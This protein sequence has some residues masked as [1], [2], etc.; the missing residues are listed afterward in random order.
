MK[1]VFHNVCLTS[2]FFLTYFTVALSAAAQIVPDATLP[3]NSAVTT[4]GQVHA[5]N[6]GTT[7][8]VNLY[9]SFQDF[10]VP[11][12]NTAYF[13]NASQVQNILT[14]VTGSSASDI[15]GTLRANGNANLYLLNPNGITFGQNAKLEI[16]GSFTGSTASSF[17]FSDGSEFS[18]KNP[19]APPLLT[20]SITPGLQYGQ[21][22]SRSTLSNASSLI[23]REG[24]GITLQGGSISSTGVLTAP[25][26]TVQVLGSHVSLLNNAL[27]DVSGANG[28]GTVLIG[29]DYQ[30]KGTVPNAS[31]THVDRGVT[32][33]ADAL[34]NGNGGRIIIWADKLTEF[35]G[36][37]TAKGVN[38][39]NPS[40]KGDGGFVEISGKQNLIFDGR[41]D[42]RAANGK[43]GTLLLDPTNV[44][45]SNG[46][47]LGTTL[48]QASLETQLSS[49]NVTI[50]ATNEIVIG[51]LDGNT[52][53]SSLGSITFIADSDGDNIGSFSMSPFDLIRA[54]ERNVSISGASVTVGS[55]QTSSSIING[56]A[57][58]G[59]DISISSTVG[60]ITTGALIASSSTVNGN[61][62]NG[63]NITLSSFGNIS[64]NGFSAIDSSSSTSNGSAG[65]GGDIMLSSFTGNIFTQGLLNSYSQTISGGTTG[66]GG[67]ISLITNTGNISTDFIQAYSIAYSYTTGGNSGNGGTISLTTNTGNISTAKLI[68]WSRSDN[69]IAGNG[70]AISLRTNVGN[71]S[72]ND[73]RSMSQG[74]NASIGGT[75]TLATNIG[76][77]STGRF[78]SSGYGTGGNGG[79]ITLTAN[80]GNISTESLDASSY[81]IYSNAN[82]GGALSL[83]TNVGNIS[84]GDLYS[85]SYA[86]SAQGNPNA[87]DGGNISL[88]SDLGNIFINGNV[89]SF[90][91]SQDNATTRNGGIIS[92]SARQGDI[93][94][95]PNKSISS[96]SVA[97]LGIAGNAGN[98]FIEAKNSIANLSISTLSSSTG[99]GTVQITGTGDVSILNTNIITSNFLEIPDPLAPSAPVILPIPNK[100]GSSGAVSISGIGNLTFNN[101]SIQSDTKGSNPAGNVTI[102][103]QGSIFFDRSFVNSSTS[104]T[105]SAGNIS[106]MANRG[107]TITGANSGLFAQTKSS[108]NAGNINVTA[109]DLTLLG[110]ASIQT[111]TLSS[112]LAGNIEV[113]VANNFSLTG[114]GTGLFSDTAFGSSGNGGNIFVDPQLVT[115]QDGAKISVGSL[116]SGIGG[117]IFIF[118]DRLI[119][120]N[121][122]S[123][124]AE[125]ASSNGGN[126]TLNIPAYLL[127]RNG[128]QISTTAGTALAGGNGGNININAGFIIGVKG[129][130]SDIFANAF[131]GNGGNVNITTN[132]IYGLEFRPLLTSFSDITA[133]SQ[134]GLNG[135]VSITTPGLDPSRGLTNLPVNLADPSKQVSQSCAIGG[136]LANR[137]NRFTISGRGGL[138]KSPTDE[139]SSIHPLVELA[140]LVP[141][142]TNSISATEQKQEVTQQVPKRIVEAN[143][144]VRDSQGV[145]HLVA[146]SNPLSPAIPQLSCP[147]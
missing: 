130:N 115:L 64:T 109:N 61:A 96:F 65:N 60:N 76:D 91:F 98:I 83:T 19:Q 125:T 17:K 62:G 114:T 15:D 25:G 72:T 29:G 44:I 37:V 28:G 47:T 113:R 7:R 70:G 85:Y 128:S 57:G 116:G 4:N 89:F 39:T 87:G 147:Q 144:L 143:T 118:A 141:S 73:I 77:I 145:L 41:V 21:T 105:G 50:D 40:F 139:L 102:I 88:K 58:D 3:V 22:D 101:S 38:L 55:I 34:Q 104:S 131:K 132:G 138:P 67:A 27:I 94:A 54:S 24:Q 134:F 69:G 99:A 31:E 140:D 32:I 95:S 35:Y 103:S 92:L 100:L 79:T 108:G 63:G 10:S 112:G 6:G 127:L 123:I 18:A 78:E 97:Q 119:L 82:N 46:S 137:D 90:S 81:A 1:P 121:G 48:T 20:M 93:I 5:I 74:V 30:G 86:N 36:T 129:E 23:V 120:L 146:A 51:T 16:G 142:S 49:A 42:L 136:K 66:N 133:S 110:G 111:T 75:I 2:A 122:S 135:T 53:T 71:I 26:G 117:N 43:L 59:G 106:V 12:N 107:I 126:I 9:H 11:T 80:I 33:S 124:T 56:N 84:T 13:N 52:L 68:S 14:R 45:I 8:G